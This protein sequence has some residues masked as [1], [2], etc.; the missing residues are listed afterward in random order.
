MRNTCLIFLILFFMCSCRFKQAN[1]K[2]TNVETTNTNFQSEFEKTE[3]QGEWNFIINPPKVG[4]ISTKNR[5]SEIPSLLPPNYSMT[6]DSAVFGDDE[7]SDMQVFY[8][9]HKNN[10]PIFKIFLQNDNNDKISAIVILNS[11]Y[12]IINT[13]LCVGTN[14]RTLKKTFSIKESYFDYSSGLFIYC[15]GFDGAFSI[16]LEDEEFD[17]LETLSDNKKIKSIIIY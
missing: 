14:F 7:F 4:L 17:S 13:E 5:I 10:K 2:E 9:V 16:D 6:K 11:E 3:K 1:N 15:H 8:A 12:N